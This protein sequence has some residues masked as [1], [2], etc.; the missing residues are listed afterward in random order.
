MGWI[1]TGYDVKYSYF[2]GC[3]VKQENKK[4]LPEDKMRPE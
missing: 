2:S 3:L 1:G 4:Y